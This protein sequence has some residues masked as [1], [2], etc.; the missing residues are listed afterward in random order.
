MWVAW[1]FWGCAPNPALRFARLPPMEGCYISSQFSV[2]QRQIAATDTEID[3][4]VYA[5]YALSAAEI[6]VVEGRA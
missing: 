5:L 3:A 2:I 4:L 6:A 1:F